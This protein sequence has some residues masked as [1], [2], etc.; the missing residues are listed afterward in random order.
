MFFDHS[1]KTACRILFFAGC[2]VLLIPS[3]A[4]GNWLYNVVSFTVYTTDEFTR[5]G[6]QGHQIWV[7]ILA[8]VVSF[9]AFVVA[10]HEMVVLLHKTICVLCAKKF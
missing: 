9:T 6:Y 5:V 3:M 10:W 8:G 2:I 1:V 4:C 7:G